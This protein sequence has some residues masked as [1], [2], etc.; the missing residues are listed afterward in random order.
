MPRFSEAEIEGVRTLFDREGRSKFDVGDEILRLIPWGKDGENNGSKAS[1]QEMAERT[2]EEFATISDRRKV[3]ALVPPRERS[4]AVY[5][6]V[7]YE[8]TKQPEATRAGLLLL[9]REGRAPTPSGR[10]TVN[11]V[12]E[13]T[14]KAPAPRSDDPITRHLPERLAASTPA[15]KAEAARAILADPDVR[16]AA[17]RPGSPVAEA[18]EDVADEAIRR[19]EEEAGAPPTESVRTF[20]KMVKEAKD[21]SPAYQYDRLMVAVTAFMAAHEAEAVADDIVHSPHTT[22]LDHYAG[23][24]DRVLA[25]WQALR[26]GLQEQ[27]RPRLVPAG[28][29][30]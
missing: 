10:W 14:G 1:M 15:E 30:S 16:E 29:A 17:S 9:V 13:R 28:S 4:L 5:W 12:R 24:A 8:I 11:A 21:A 26:R 6:S 22:R 27:A 18:M 3:S 2:G 7:Y 25:W 20:K 19:A 23:G